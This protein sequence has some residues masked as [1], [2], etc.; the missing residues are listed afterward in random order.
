MVVTTPP[1]ARVEMNE[2]IRSFVC[3]TPPASPASAPAPTANGIARMPSSGRVAA[4]MT[5]VMDATAC[6]DRS[7]PPMRMTKVAPAAIRN[8]V[9][10]SDVSTI[11]V[12]KLKNEG[13]HDPHQDDQPDKGSAA[14]SDRRGRAGCA[15]S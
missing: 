14:G 6:T 5:L 13:V 3:D 4:T 1:T 10:V 8:R 11:R 7:I 12:R 9:M 15:R 2:G